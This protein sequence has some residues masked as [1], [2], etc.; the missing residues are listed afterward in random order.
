METPSY[1]QVGLRVRH[2]SLFIQI[3]VL[4][5]VEVMEGGSRQ[6]H[7]KVHPSQIRH[8]VTDDPSLLTD[9]RDGNRHTRH[10]SVT[11]QHTFSAER[12]GIFSCVAIRTLTH[13]LAQSKR[14]KQR[15]VE[16]CYVCS[17]L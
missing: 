16:H 14:Q 2:L 5:H 10:T 15:C 13:T 17:L 3:T 6:V 4:L 9:F 11:F 12:R 8:F 1:E 7:T